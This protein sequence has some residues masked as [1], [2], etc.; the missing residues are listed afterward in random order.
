MCECIR[1]IERFK[2]EDLLLEYEGEEY[3]K[4]INNKWLNGFKVELKG[5]ND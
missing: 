1:K 2:M 4:E 5:N 3:L